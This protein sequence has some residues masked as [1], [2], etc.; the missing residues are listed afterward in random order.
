MLKVSLVGLVARPFVL[1][2]QVLVFVFL[3]LGDA[4]FELTPVFNALRHD[5]GLSELLLNLLFIHIDL[6]G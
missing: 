6:I 3:A 2:D 5:T 4:I 1:P